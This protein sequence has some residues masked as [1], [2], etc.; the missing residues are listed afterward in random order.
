MT[1]LRGRAPGNL[2]VVEGPDSVGKTTLAGAFVNRLR[3]AAIPARLLAF[4]GNEAGTLGR[5]VY[6]LHHDPAAFDISRID[7]SSLQALHVA[8]HIDAIEHEIRP[9]VESGETV[10]LD[11]FWWSTW[12]YGIEGGAPPASLHALI[13]LEKVHWRT[14]SPQLIF[15]VKRHAPFDNLT[16]RERFRRLTD[17][18]VDLAGRTEDFQVHM[19]SNM[20]T[21]AEEVVVMMAKV[22]SLAATPKEGPRVSRP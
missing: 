18:Y 17:H 11:R 8:A 7:P 21:I 22:S 2:Y 1:E 3:E 9:R 6:R 10:V 13:E 16:H 15:L 19:L 5:H 14:L 12:V 4:P 20:G